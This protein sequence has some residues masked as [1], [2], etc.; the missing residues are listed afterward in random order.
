[1]L[2]FREIAANELDVGIFDDFIRHQVV[3]RCWRKID[4][5]WVIQDVD[6][7]DD[8][9]AAETADRADMLRDAAERGRF[10]FGAFEGDRLKGFT[11]V[12][13]D[14]LGSRGQYRDLVQLHVSEDMRG[15]GIGRTLFGCAADAA[16]RFG[17]E[18]LYISANS[19]VESQAFYRAMGCVEAEEYDARHAAEEP[20]DCQMEYKL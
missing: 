9:D 11:M 17:G 15:R 7:V 18:K 6:F 16:R 13:P 1:M 2:I 8:W 14:P 10:V 19:S 20:F 3:T 12:S 5:E 4:G